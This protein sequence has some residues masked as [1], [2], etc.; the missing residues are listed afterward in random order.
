MIT[1]YTKP[2]CPQCTATKRHL[3]KAGVEYVVADLTAD[4]GRHLD[5]VKALGH[6]AAPVVTID[7]GETLTDHWDGYRPDRID[8][9]QAAA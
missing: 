3:D 7:D 9:I 2:H 6:Q 1:V 8:Q 4:N 5:Y